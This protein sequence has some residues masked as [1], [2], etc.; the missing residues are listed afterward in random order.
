MVEAKSYPAK[1]FALALTSEFP[2]L[3][4]TSSYRTTDRP[5]AR[6]SCKSFFAENPLSIYPLSGMS[7]LSRPARARDVFLRFD[8]AEMRPEEARLSPL[9]SQPI[10]LLLPLSP[11]MMLVSMLLTR[12]ALLSPLLAPDRP[13]KLC[14]C[15]SKRHRL[16]QRRRNSKNSLK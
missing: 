12:A 1:I 13:C 5:L 2:F 8:G 15:V 16:G 10:L 7:Q 6:A 3:I 14:V 4:Y 11:L 9:M